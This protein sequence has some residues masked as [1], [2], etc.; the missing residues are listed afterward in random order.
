MLF[1]LP[2]HCLFPH[3]VD[4]LLYAACVFRC[5]PVRDKE[6]LFAYA[7]DQQQTPGRAYM[8]II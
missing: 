2:I 5:L 7:F 3:L 1:A 8:Y 6:N 4:F